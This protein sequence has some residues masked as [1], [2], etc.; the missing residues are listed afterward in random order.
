MRVVMKVVWKAAMTETKTDVP[1]AGLMAEE[2]VGL[3]A[4]K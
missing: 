3:L 4:T 2:M 1:L